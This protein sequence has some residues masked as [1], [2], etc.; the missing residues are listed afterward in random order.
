V[1][2]LCW[3]RV[4]ACIGRAISERALLVRKPGPNGAASLMLCWPVLDA[5]VFEA[6]KALLP[7]TDGILGGTLSSRTNEWGG[8]YWGDSRMEVVRYRW[9]CG[10]PRRG[11]G[12]RLWGSLVLGGTGLPEICWPRLVRERS[13]GKPK[14]E[15]A[16]VFHSCRCS[17]ILA[18]P[19][20][21]RP[22]HGRSLSRPRREP[23]Q[24]HP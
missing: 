22:V 16:L 8:E 23:I 18:G 24:C 4:L 1:D 7:N 13:P 17:A 21:N 12:R 15:A 5:D 14:K 3:R 19:F 20:S 6:R 9:L 11:L 10:R 2:T